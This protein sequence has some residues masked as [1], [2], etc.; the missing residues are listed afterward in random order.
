[1]TAPVT[2]RRLN[3]KRLWWL[4]RV[5]IPASIAF[6][7]IALLQLASA[8]WQSPQVPWR[9]EPLHLLLALMVVAAIGRL[10]WRMA[11]LRRRL[12]NR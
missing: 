8:A 10:A 5:I 3:R 12:G 7:I 6:G 2:G 4:S 11:R 9:R 1:M